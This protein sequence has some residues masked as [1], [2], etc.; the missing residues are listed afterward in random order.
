MILA[1][2]TAER[3]FYEGKWAQPDLSA[4]SLRNLLVKKERFFVGQ[5]RGR[6]GRVLDLGCGGGW[7]LFTTVG[8][9]LG[10]DLSRSSLRAA[11]V[12][13][14]G[15]AQA[16]LAGLPFAEGAFD[17]VVS[18]DVLGH[19]PLERKDAVLAEI[20]R[21]LRPGGRTLHY[22]EA[23]GQDPLLTWARRDPAL[24]LRHVVAPEG[25]VGM[26]TASRTFAR[27]RRAG[28]RPLAEVAA[29]RGLMYVGRV[30]QLFDNEYAARS[31][32]L[33]VLVALCRALNAVGPVAL[34]ANLAVSA[35]LEVGDRLLPLDWA[36]GVMVCYE[37]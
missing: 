16:D 2:E 12:I 15:G 20:R 1:D 11:R 37:R 34:A 35:A 33:R 19:V 4:G 18:S 26:E 32:R 29:Y 36:G 7:R 21:V 8:P 14:A 30:V 22:V 25:H 9:V 13:Y 17:F 23:E 27:F 6:R 31:R 5:L 10:V 28:F 24:Y 3:D